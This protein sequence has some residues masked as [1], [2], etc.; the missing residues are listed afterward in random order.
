METSTKGESTGQGEKNPLKVDTRK[1]YPSS[2]RGAPMK[3]GKIIK[4]S[5]QAS[6]RNIVRWT[7]PRKVRYTKRREQQNTGGKKRRDPWVMSCGG[8]FSFHGRGLRE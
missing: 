3:P 5:L 8:R 1:S 2:L 6:R 7:D 4:E